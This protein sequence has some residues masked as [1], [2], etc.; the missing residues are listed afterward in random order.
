MPGL[1]IHKIES[2]NPYLNLAFEDYLFR[3]GDL[4]GKQILLLWR[5]RPCVVLGRFQNPWM[6]CRISELEQAGVDLVRRQS[7]GGTVYQ[8]L[9][10]LNYTFISP[11]EDYDKHNNHKIVISALE[12]LGVPCKRSGRNDLITRNL[13]EVYKFSGSAF[14]ENRD[15]CFHHGTLLIN[16]ELAKLNRL[17]NPVIRN[18]DCKGIASHRSKVI[19][20]SQIVPELT[21]Q[22]VEAEI[23]EAFAS[24]HGQQAVVHNWT[25]AQLQEKTEVTELAEKF[26]SSKWRMGETPRFTQ[27]LQHDFSFGQLK[28]ELAAHRGEIVDSAF[29]CREVDQVQLADWK[30]CLIGKAYGSVQLRPDASP[31]ETEFFTWFNQT[32]S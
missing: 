9:G 21:M 22:Q 28:L 3:S 25:E 13:Q 16:S 18:L 19:N 32:V 10:N 11:R 27:K 2:L 8:D 31:E 23:K 29:E 15:R 26:Q 24:F 17:L 20:L 12:K 7:G 5:N 1:T 4:Q 6:E 14:K 30:A